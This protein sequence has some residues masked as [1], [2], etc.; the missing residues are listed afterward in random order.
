[1]HELH[2]I[3]RALGLEPA[4]VI[5]FD[6]SVWDTTRAGADVV[7]I[8]ARTTGKEAKTLKRKNTSKIRRMAL[9]MLVCTLAQ[10]VGFCIV[11]GKR[12]VRDSAATTAAAVALLHCP[13]LMK[14]Q[15]T[16]KVT[17]SE[18]RGGV[19]YDLGASHWLIPQQRGNSG[20]TCLKG[21]IGKGHLG[22]SLCNT[23][24]DTSK[25]RGQQ[26]WHTTN[27]DHLTDHF[28]ELVRRSTPGFVGA[29]PTL[30]AH[31][32]SCRR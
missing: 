21:E 26:L 22:H 5:E 23:L 15:G 11:C 3:L 10:M 27:T 20:I 13:D 2:A 6:T 31:R 19:I 8:A 25:G 32:T 16:R 9:R 29:G 30:E 1:M 17:I 14:D 7:V 4:S 12:L 24:L 28:A 18:G